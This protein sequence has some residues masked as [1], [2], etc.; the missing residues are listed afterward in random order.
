M[1]NASFVDPEIYKIVRT[2]LDKHYPNTTLEQ[3]NCYMTT[4]R[5]DEIVKKFYMADLLFKP[6]DLWKEL[7]P[8]MKDVINKC[9]ASSASSSLLLFLGIGIGIGIGILIFFLRLQR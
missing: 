6:D 9:D 5:N 4:I 2:T 7:N 8:Y 3:R 1:S